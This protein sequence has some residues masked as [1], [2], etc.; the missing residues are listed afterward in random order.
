MRSIN[1]RFTYLL[2]YT[3]GIIFINLT[4]CAMQMAAKCVLEVGDTVK[5]KSDSIRFLVSANVGFLGYCPTVPPSWLR[6]C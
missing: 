5:D 6:L 2:T 1:L 4:L 3:H